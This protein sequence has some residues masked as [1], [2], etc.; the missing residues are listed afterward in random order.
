VLAGQS[1][2]SGTQKSTPRPCGGLRKPPPS[3][4]GHVIWIVMENSSYGDIVGSSDAPYLNTL[5]HECGLAANY[6][7]LAHPSLPNYIGMT[8]GSTQ[9]ITDDGSPSEH[10]LSVP[11][12]F[13]QLP[14]GWRALDESMR[15]TCDLSNGGGYAVRHNPAVYYTNIRAGCAHSDVP[16]TSRPKLTARFTFITPN[17]CHDMHDCSTPTGDTWLAGFV[18]KILRNHVYRSGKAVVF[19]TWDESEGSGNNQ[20][21]TLVLSRYTRPGTVARKAFN[22]YSLLRTTEALLGIRAKLGHAATA[23]DMRAAFH[24]R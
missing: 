8:S 21:A 9:G 11:S 2:A 10:S 1:I 19:I 7:A 23:A 18:P 22:H 4:F 20:V 24:L 3:T 13:S 16:L 15:R 17:L 5:A 6:S 14:N 12:I